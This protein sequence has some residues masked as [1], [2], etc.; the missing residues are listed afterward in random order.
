MRFYLNIYRIIFVC[1][2]YRSNC[3]ELIKTIRFELHNGFDY[4]WK[5]RNIAC[6]IFCS[7]FKQRFVPSTFSIM[8]YAVFS[9]WQCICRLPFAIVITTQL[10]TKTHAHVAIPIHTHQHKVHDRVN[11]KAILLNVMSPNRAISPS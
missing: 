4:T 9:H 3:A 11:D 2:K 1:S 8:L 10:P 5:N 6:L 7:H